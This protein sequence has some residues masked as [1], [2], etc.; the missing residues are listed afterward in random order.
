MKPAH[1]WVLRAAALGSLEPAISTAVIGHILSTHRV[2]SRLQFDGTAN[3]G[4]T[5]PTSEGS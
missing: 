1:K 4:G 2:L 5:L 3:R